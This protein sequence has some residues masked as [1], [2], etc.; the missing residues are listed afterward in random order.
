MKFMFTNNVMIPRNR[1]DISENR[2]VCSP[3]P[4]ANQGFDMANQRSDMDNG[5]RNGGGKFERSDNFGDFSK[6]VSK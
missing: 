2:K 1:R 3:L 5:L 6:D 4:K